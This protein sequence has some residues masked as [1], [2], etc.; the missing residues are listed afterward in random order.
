[1]IGFTGMPTWST[2]SATSLVGDRRQSGSTSSSRWVIAITS[3]T[4]DVVEQAAGGCRIRPDSGCRHREAYF[5]VPHRLCDAV[6]AR[7][8]PAGGTFFA[9]SGF[10]SGAAGSR[11]CRLVENDTVSGALPSRQVA[12]RLPFLRRPSLAAWRRV[13]LT[14]FTRCVPGRFPGPLHSAGTGRFAARHT[15]R[16]CLEM[17]VS[18]GC[19]RAAYRSLAVAD[20]GAFGRYVVV[21]A[22]T[23]R[24]AGVRGHCTRRVLP[25]FEVAV[26]GGFLKKGRLCACRALSVV[27]ALPS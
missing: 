9:C 24:C 6:A 5:S 11:E 19:C 15:R 17:A 18:V 13:F 25:A 27:L 12:C 10:P 16:A 7:L 22:R 14:A 21:G 23:A 3:A 26:L 1:M 2:S 4:F 8:V 20:S